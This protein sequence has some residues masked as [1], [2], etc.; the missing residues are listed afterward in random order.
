MLHL[1]ITT[2]HCPL[3]HQS[4]R[5]I[6]APEPKSERWSSQ[7]QPS[8]ARSVE[9]SK[10]KTIG[11]FCPQALSA[12]VSLSE[13]SKNG[14]GVK[15]QWTTYRPTTRSLQSERLKQ[16]DLALNIVASAFLN[17]WREAHPLP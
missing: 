2:Q 17:D 4:E 9:V 14:E 7:G 1:P 5:R 11:Q 13:L 12:D 6:G 8:G 10:V 16:I 3:D 15:Q